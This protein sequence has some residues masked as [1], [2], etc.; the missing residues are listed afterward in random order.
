MPCPG[1]QRSSAVWIEA[2]CGP[3]LS[4]S[5][6]HKCPNETDKAG[7]LSDSLHTSALSAGRDMAYAGSRS[8]TLVVPLVVLFH[9]HRLLLKI[10]KQLERISVIAGV[11]DLHIFR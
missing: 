9:F 8:Y 6:G 10:K 7:P 11:P 5:G 3:A 1:Q 4:V 2:D